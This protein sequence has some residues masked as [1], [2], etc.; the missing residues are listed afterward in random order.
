MTATIMDLT[1]KSRAAEIVTLPQ[2]EFSES[3]LPVLVPGAVFYW[4]IGYEY[5]TGGTKRRVSEIRV[6]RM[7]EWSELAIESIKKAGLELYRQ[8]GGF[9]QD[10]SP[11]E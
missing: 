11:E 8:F 10:D 5:V 4:S 3:D 1:D 7:P 9:G 6:Q 2:E